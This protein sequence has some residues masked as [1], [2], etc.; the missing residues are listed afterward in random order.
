MTFAVVLFYV[1]GAI[2]VI[3]GIAMLA[4]SEFVVFTPG[5]AWLVDITA[6]GWIT[7][8]LGA[9][10]ILVGWGLTTG[11]E[12]ARVVGIALAVVAAVNAFFVIPIYAVWGILAF[13]VSVMVIYA[14]AF[15]RAST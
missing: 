13:A 4:N 15:D 5:G 6:W 12:M 8:I 3:Y 11:N 10:E 7:L 1:L 14:L 2:N 9:V